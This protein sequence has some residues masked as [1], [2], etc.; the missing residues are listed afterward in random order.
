MISKI[1]PKD[2]DAL[3]RWLRQEEA[4]NLPMLGDLKRFGTESDFSEFWVQTTDSGQW[5]A[6]IRRFFEHYTVFAPE[7]DM[8]GEK[9]ADLSFME[10]LGVFLMFSSPGSVSGRQKT[11][12]M[13]L[14]GVH[15]DM[16]ESV[17]MILPGDSSLVRQETTPHATDH[18]SI[19]FPE[20]ATEA[21]VQELGELIF[22]TDAFRRNYRNAQEVAE[23][24]RSRLR[25]GGVRHAVVRMAGRILSHANT[26]TE[27]DGLALISGVTTRPEAQRKGYA[28]VLVSFLCRELLREGKMPCLFAKSPAALALYNRLGF[29]KTGAY[30]TWR[31]PYSNGTE[32]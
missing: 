14:E 8:D 12:R 5:H 10:E 3:A 16:E 30:T 32:D 21:D 13:L 1:M 22:E 19:P 31:R 2:A 7:L 23:G 11:V 6:V 24:I 15:G 26:T 27:T 17:S 9:E 28:A 25:A 4:L 29:V 18:D 20:Y